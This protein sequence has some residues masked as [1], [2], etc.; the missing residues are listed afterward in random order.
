ME[1]NIDILFRFCSN[2]GK[3]SEEIKDKRLE[4]REGL[5]VIS[6]RIAAKQ[7]VQFWEY[8]EK[9]QNYVKQKEYLG[10]LDKIPQ[11]DRDGNLVSPKPPFGPKPEQ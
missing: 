9:M 6:N 1:H 7:T 2:C 4:C 8:L 10:E 3:S 5:L 11:R